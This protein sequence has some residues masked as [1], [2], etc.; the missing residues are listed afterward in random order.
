LELDKRH[1]EDQIKIIE[2]S[3]LQAGTAMERDSYKMQLDDV[4]ASIEKHFSIG[5]THDK[6]G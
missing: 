5:V 4:K 1:R 3:A 2:G 6:I